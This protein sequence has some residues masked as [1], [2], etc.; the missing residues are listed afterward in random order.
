MALSVWAPLNRTSHTKPCHLWKAL[1]SDVSVTVR[2]EICCCGAVQEDL[3]R[4]GT[5][6]LTRVWSLG[7]C[8]GSLASL[9]GSLF[10][11]DFHCFPQDQEKKFIGQETG[12]QFSWTTY[13]KTSYRLQT[14][15]STMIVMD[16]DSEPEYLQL[17]GKGGLW[18]PHLPVSLPSRRTLREFLRNPWEQALKA[19][20]LQ[21]FFK[22]N[23]SSII[24]LWF[25]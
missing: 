16:P 2:K 20:S 15:F 22:A 25:K 18:A 14:H 4:G 7:T 17:T 1:G 21:C 5:Q 13:L 12:A 6:G 19:T 24:I 9:L 3:C 23:F 8:S 11:K 10:S